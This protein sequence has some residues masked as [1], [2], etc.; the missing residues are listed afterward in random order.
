MISFS[1]QVDCEITRDKTGRLKCTCYMRKP[2][3]HLLALDM[4]L[5]NGMQPLTLQGLL[6]EMIDIERS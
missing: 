6:S 3:K 5:S 4:E 1:K 2:C